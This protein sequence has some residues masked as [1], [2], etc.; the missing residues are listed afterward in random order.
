MA[1]NEYFCKNERRLFFLYKTRRL[2]QWLYIVISIDDIKGKESLEA[3]LK[4]RPEDVRQN[5]A[6]FIAARSALRV[7]PIAVDGFQFSD[8]S[9][10]RHLQ[11]RDL[12]AVPILRSVLTSA[13]A[14]K[15]PTGEVKASASACVS[16][17]AAG[18]AG[19]A[20]AVWSCGRGDCRAWEAHAEADGTCGIDVAPLNV[21]DIKIKTE[22]PAVREKLLNDTDP[23][24]GADW[25]FWIDWYEKILR[26]DPQDW[27]LLYE[28]AVSDDIDWEASPREVNAAIARIVEKHRLLREIA[29]LKAQRDQLAS[30]TA[31][32]ATRSHNMPP[33]LVD[34]N[35]HV[36]RSFQ[37]IWE[38]LDA[39]EEELRSET[40]EPSRLAKVGQAIVDAAAVILKY[41]GQKAD[42][43][44]TEASKKI[45]TAGGK[46][47]VVL[48]GSQT[49][50]AQ[51]IG[52][53]LIEFAR[54]IM[55]G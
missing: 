9:Q 42:I 3:W 12:T 8:W 10:E 34:D 4:E 54:L 48:V 49:E 50:A 38:E 46:A 6:V 55:G 26:V 17:I 2:S 20:A 19:A 39:A 52:H 43:M 13:V 53:E 16:P 27:D 1:G 44:I 14:A 36:A 33:E 18:S 31:S 5:C 15:L 7:M 32:A 30:F 24:R 51:K 37:I 28:V 22:W 29:D 40:P 23:D 47:I 21:D 45:G 25:S 41:C 35:G 11:E